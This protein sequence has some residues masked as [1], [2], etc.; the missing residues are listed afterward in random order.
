MK[1]ALAGLLV[2]GMLLGM[3]GCSSEKPAPTTEETTVPV[4]EAATVEVETQ[5]APVVKLVGIVMP[6]AGSHFAG[7]FLKARLEADGYEVRLTYAADAAEQSQAISQMASEGAAL[8]IA[9]EAPADVSVPVIAYGGEAAYCVRFSSQTA[10]MLQAQ[11]LI[12]KLD[13][14]AG[15]TLHIELVGENPGALEV[16]QPW[17]DAGTL[18]IPSGK[19]ASTLAD[20]QEVL[21]SFYSEGAALDAVLCAGDAADVI[22]AIQSGYAGGNTVLIAGQGGEPESLQR[23]LDGTQTMTIYCNIADEA[24]AA[25]KLATALLAGET[26]E[27]NILL[28]PWAIDRDNLNMLVEAGS[29]AW[30]ADGNLVPVA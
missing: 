2:A 28:S 8:L 21:S 29:Y 11:Y 7:E 24:S 5:T 16:L 30:D 1:K 26:V 14:S 25:L 19:T 4:T 17:L 10:G 22:G 18:T 20:F 15:N 6:E 3:A 9:P 12:Q 13:L 23:I 27:A